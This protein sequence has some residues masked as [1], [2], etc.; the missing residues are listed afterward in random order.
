[1]SVAKAKPNPFRDTDSV[2]QRMQPD[3]GQNNTM[4]RGIGSRDDDERNELAHG[5]PRRRYTVQQAK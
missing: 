3:K 5:L 4:G 1:M 2:P